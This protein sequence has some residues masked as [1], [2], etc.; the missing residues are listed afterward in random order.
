MVQVPKALHTNRKGSPDDV[1]TLVTMQ[2]P[3]STTKVPVQLRL[4]AEIA[5]EFR[6]FCAARDLELSEA[7]VLMFESYKR[8]HGA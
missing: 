5:R 7:F 8:S 4:T 6:V 2:R 3:A 1:P